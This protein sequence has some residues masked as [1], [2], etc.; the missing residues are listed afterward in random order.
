MTSRPA[1]PELE[2]AIVREL[3]ERDARYR[4]AAEEWTQVA[5]DV[6]RLALEGSTPEAVID[7]LRRARAELVT[8]GRACPAC[9]GGM[10]CRSPRSTWTTSRAT[11]GQA[12]PSPRAPMPS[13]GRTAP[14]RARCWNRSALP[15]LTCCPT[16]RANSFAKG[17]RRPRSPSTSS[18]GTAA[19]TRWCAAA[20]ATAS[21]MSTIPRST[22][23]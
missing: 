6:K 16:R 18:A 5:L 8:V 7:H 20:A 22:K 15:S 3:L 19:P 2:R 13:A 12:S 23:S 17:R 10:R 11:A 4:P 21:T 14:A 9:E 1:V